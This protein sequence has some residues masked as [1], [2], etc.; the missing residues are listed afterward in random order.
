MVVIIEMDIVI[1][2]GEE[3]V[4]VMVGVIEMVGILD[5]RSL[6]VVQE[7]DNILKK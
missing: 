1:M 4:A 7:R 3:M 6:V 2:M 5:S